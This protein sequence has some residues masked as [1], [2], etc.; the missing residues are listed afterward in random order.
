MRERIRAVPLFADL[1]DADLDRLAASVEEVTVAPEDYLF[2]EGDF[3]DSAYIITGGELEILTTSGG[4]EVLLAHEHAAIFDLST[5][6]K[7]RVTGADAESFLNRVCANDMTRGPGSVIYTG[8]LND[9]GGFVSDLTAQRIGDQE[10]LLFVGTSAIK[11][12]FAWLNK[13]LELGE[14]VQLHDETERLATL[15]VV[16]PY[17]SELMASLD[18]DD[19]NT[20]RYFRHGEFVLQGIRLRA[21]KISYVGEY[22][23]ELTCDVEQISKLYELLTGAGAQPAGLFAQS[24][25]R[26]EKGYLSY[27]HDL[28]NDVNPFEAALDFALDWKSEFVGKQSLEVC[29]HDSP[30]KSRISIILDDPEANPIGNEPVYDGERIVGQTTSAAFGYRIGYPIAIAY[31][32]SGSIERAKDLTVKLNIA[33]TMFT[34]KV[35]PGAVYDPAG[36]RLLKAN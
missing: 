34:G 10:Y 6:G 3:G 19:L 33:G 7:I 2:H 25:M 23:W 31:L 4:R 14:R 15:G 24:S 13:N 27:G 5:F 9:K 21:A 30:D 1:P 29:R 18:A 22:G 12:D 35:V 32:E 26:I 28:D 16:G 17:C 36:T 8:M 20:L 11:H